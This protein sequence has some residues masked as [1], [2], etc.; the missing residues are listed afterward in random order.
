MFRRFL[1]TT[2]ITTSLAVSPVP[3]TALEAQVRELLP[4]IVVRATDLADNTVIE[5]ADGTRILRFSNGMGN[6]GEGKLFLKGVLPRVSAERQAVTQRVFSSDG[7]FRDREAGIFL[8]H[9]GHSHIHI[10][11]WARYRLRVMLP[12]D[13]IGEVVAESEKVS[14]CI[15]DLRLAR[16]DIPNAAL[17]PEFTSCSST[18]QGLSVGWVDVYSKNLPGQSINLRDLPDGLYWLESEVDPMN[19]ILESRDDNN[20]TRIPFTLGNVSGFPDSFEPNNDPATVLD[21]AP[22]Q[23]G[24][25][26]LGPCNP[27]RR[28]KPLNLHSTIDRDVF[29]FYVNSAGTSN[30]FVRI[31]FSPVDGNLDL[32]LRNSAGEE[33]DRAAADVGGTERINFTNLPMGWYIA[34][35]LPKPGETH[36]RYSLTVVPPRNQPPAVEILSPAKGNVDLIHSREAFTVTWNHSDPEANEAWVTL[37]VN[38]EPILNENAIQVPTSVLTDADVG[39]TVINS[40]D[41]EPGVYW[42]YAEITDG[43]STTGSWSTGTVTFH[44]F[45]EE[46]EAESPTLD[47]NGNGVN[48][49]CEFDRG[50]LQDCDADGVADVCGVAP[51]AD[52]DGIPDACQAPRFR[53]GDSNHDGSVD[54]GDAT[55][56]LGVL[57]LGN[58]TPTCIEASDTN[59]DREFDISDGLTILNH[60]FL[61]GAVIS[62]P[63]PECGRDPQ[64]S[65]PGLGC[66]QYSFCS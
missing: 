64:S 58:A 66:E 23:P 55:Y 39:I 65:R 47:C 57:F 46:C 21:S 44:S 15:L 45:P 20:V 27:S 10:D 37:Y 50:L 61:G 19:H 11:D 9:A 36:P 5:L 48:D 17:R 30:T 18:T 13:G 16:P 41:L 26:N 31:D 53:R 22:G 33:I 52:D 54:I 51:D 28:V 1:A 35:V 24:S 38:D 60:L 40:A 2:L 14:F 59:D 34:E 63:G 62:P 12:D 43:G 25:A 6:Y 3:N 42:I 49:T 32:V 4:D 7:T 56:L 8:F 29:G